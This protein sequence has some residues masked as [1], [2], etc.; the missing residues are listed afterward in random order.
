M[1]KKE[2]KT[3]VQGGYEHIIAGID[4]EAMADPKNNF[5]YLKFV[6]RS[7]LREKDVK[8]YIEIGLMTQ[9][10]LNKNEN[11]HLMPC[12]RYVG[13][14]VN[15]NNTIGKIFSNRIGEILHNSIGMI[16]ERERK[17]IQYN[18]VRRRAMQEREEEEKRWQEETAKNEMLEI[19]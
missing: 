7:L 1:K 11:S 18:E 12:G 10:E 3:E 14:V 5:E 9:E 6:M 8:R 13:E 2:K 19:G 17:V 15:A 4:P 16:Q